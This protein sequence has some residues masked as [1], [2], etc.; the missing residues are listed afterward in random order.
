MPIFAM[1]EQYNVMLPSLKFRILNS[2]I[3]SVRVIY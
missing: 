1:I 3:F 2:Q